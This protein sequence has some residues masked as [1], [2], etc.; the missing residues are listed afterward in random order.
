[1]G[2]VLWLGALTAAALATVG[3]LSGLPHRF[4]RIAAGAAV[5]AIGQALFC[6]L[7]G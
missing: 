1:M 3:L 2:W 4:P 5:L 6:A 7:P